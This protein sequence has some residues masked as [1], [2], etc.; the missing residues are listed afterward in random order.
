VFVKICGVTNVDDALLA[1]GL[2]AGAVG[3]NFHNASP[4]RITTAVARDI[5]RRLPPEIL[6][7]GIFRNEPREWMVET[8]NTLGLR[9]VQL[10]GAETPEDTRWV[11]ERVPAVI[12]AFSAADPALIGGADYG[13]HR[14]MIDSPAPGSGQVFDWSNVEHVAAGREFILA[15]GLTPENVSDAIQVVRPWG[16]DVASGVESSPGHKDPAK[17]RRFIANAHRAGEKYTSGD[18]FWLQTDD[19]LFA[20]GSG[21]LFGSERRPE[22]DADSGGR[23]FGRGRL[24]D[25]QW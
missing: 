23:I 6:A 25:E 3:L 21:G 12:R 5:V 9:A 22:L 19:S 24:E 2:G 10:H 7:V 4:R 18:D 15:G 20:D 17:V 8:A 11:S 1:A 14:L 16:V 13:P